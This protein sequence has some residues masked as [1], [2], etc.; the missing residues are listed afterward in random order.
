MKD[1][2]TSQNNAQ[3]KNII[4]LQTKAKARN[5]EKSFVVEGIRMYVEVPEDK[6][7]KTYVSETFFNQMDK[8]LKDKII[9]RDFEIVSD[10]VFKKISDTIT[11]RGIMGIVKQ[12]DYNIEEFEQHL[13]DNKDN[14]KAL[15]MVLED[16]QDPG[17]LGTIFRTA[18]A[19]GVA[20]IIMSKG[21]VDIYN[22][23]VV[24]STMG[25][26]FRMPFIYVEKLSDTIEILKEND[27]KVFAAHLLGKNN[28]FDEDYSKRCAFLIGNEGNG[29]T[30]EI[31]SLAD[32]YI[33]IPMMGEVESL[34]AAVA[35]TVLMYEALRQKI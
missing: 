26:I 13:K 16:I 5:K 22:S 12:S 33:R 31:A 2:I 29:L 24:R 32:T 17:N 14:G 23:K 9:S 4:A 34:N 10:E 35:S 3:I 18:E 19:A 11:P 21:T 15:I 1:I 30:D 8:A 6:L 20:C 25:A 27:V 28:H 7:L